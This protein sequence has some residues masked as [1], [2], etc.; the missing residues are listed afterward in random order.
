MNSRASRIDTGAGVSFIVSAVIHLAVFL[1]LVWWGQ[2]FPTQPPIQE[3][4]Y[5]DVVTLP[6]PAPAAG[7]SPQKAEVPAMVTP[8]VPQAAPAPVAAAPKKT[9]PSGKASAKN[10]KPAP[11]ETAEEFNERLAK[12]EGKAEAQR[13]EEQMKK[14]GAKKKSAAA[15]KAGPPAANGTESGSSC[16]D[17][18]E[19][20]LFDAFSKTLSYKSK[21]PFLILSLKVTS[22]GKLALK[23]ALKSSEDATFGFSVMRAIDI[24]NDKFTAPQACVGHE[25]ESNFHPKE[26]SGSQTR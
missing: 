25:Y 4:Y 8:A 22:D 18:I 24:F 11:T 12:L 20:R 17:Y 23:K 3:T 19:S 26:G 21:K 7:T 15:P 14:L 2:L 10:T 1:L 9:V 5:V 6:T 16:K 13:Y